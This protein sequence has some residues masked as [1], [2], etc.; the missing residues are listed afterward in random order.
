[1]ADERRF[2]HRLL[3]GSPEATRALGIR[4]GRAA[5]A[6]DVF[7]LEG[8][9]G[10]GK[11]VL[12]QGL[13]Q[14]LGVKTPVASP[15]FVIINQHDGRLRLHHVD[16]YRAERL[17]PELEATVADAIS[18]GGVAAIEWPGLLPDDLRQGATLL[19]FSGAD[20]STREI[21]LRTDH[22]RLS[23][24]LDEAEMADAARD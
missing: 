5:K 9:F 20:G 14:G 4:L 19:R 24:A 8:A 17:D 12:V 7:L 18:A 21:E 22:A 23:Q 1:V 13:A 2:T 15:S 6:G 11:T 16:L 10:T 3:S